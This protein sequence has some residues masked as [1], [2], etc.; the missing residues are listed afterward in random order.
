MGEKLKLK[1]KLNKQT[2]GVLHVAE[3][4]LRALESELTLVQLLLRLAKRVAHAR[5]LVATASDELLEAP[6]LGAHRLA[7]RTRAALRLEASRFQARYSSRAMQ[8][9]ERASESGYLVVS[10]NNEQEDRLELY[11]YN[12]EESMN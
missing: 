1:L 11:T 7:L 5:H 12:Y 3:F 4:L 9:T 2:H 6:R 8:Q 10:V